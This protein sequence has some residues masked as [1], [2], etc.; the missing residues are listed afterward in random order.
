MGLDGCQWK[1]NH[2]VDAV[3]EIGVT[4]I[5]DREIGDRHEFGARGPL[6]GEAAAK[7]GA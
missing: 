4:Q 5:G 2:F 3:A 1:I 6:L 7:H